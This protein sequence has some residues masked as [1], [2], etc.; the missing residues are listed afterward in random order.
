M[1]DEINWLA[2]AVRVAGVLRRMVARRTTISRLLTINVAAGASVVAVLTASFSAAAVRASASA[3][4]CVALGAPGVWP[5][6]TEHDRMTAR[7]GPLH[8]THRALRALSAMANQSI[9]VPGRRV[10]AF[11]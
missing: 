1:I 8:R 3:V 10:T 2:D 5:W 4:G 9:Q 11:S 6:R 7:I